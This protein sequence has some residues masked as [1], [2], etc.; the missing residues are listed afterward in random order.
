MTAQPALPN[1]TAG[2]QPA[3]EVEAS[4]APLMDHLVELRTRLVR[5]S[6][7]IVVLF[8]AA[9]FVTQQ[10]LD[11]LLVPFSDAAHRH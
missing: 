5:I 11:Y 10:G 7:A 1:P 4:R 2:A 8:I 9:W 6:I 3:D